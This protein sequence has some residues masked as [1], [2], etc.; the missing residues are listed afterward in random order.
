ME[1]I[2]FHTDCIGS[3]KHSKMGT[4]KFMS[5]AAQLPLREVLDSRA[6]RGFQ[7]RMILGIRMQGATRKN[8]NK[9]IQGGWNIRQSLLERPVIGSGGRNCWWHPRRSS[10][11]DTKMLKRAMSGPIGRNLLQQD[12][13]AS[14]GDT[15]EVSRRCV[16]THPQSELTDSSLGHQVKL[17]NSRP[18]VLRSLGF[19]MSPV[20]DSRLLVAVSMSCLLTGIGFG[21]FLTFP[22]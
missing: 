20:Q 2:Q 5:M 16:L 15:N 13:S 14:P 9:C 11:T 4:L 10:S 17:A 22:W 12:S 8:W 1:T 6:L 18:S 21:C 19:T 7:R 3:D